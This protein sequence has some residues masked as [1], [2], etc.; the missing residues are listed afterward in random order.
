MGIIYAKPWHWGWCS[1]PGGGLVRAGRE[2][3]FPPAPGVI[4][5]GTE[6]LRA[7]R[8]KSGAELYNL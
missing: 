8:A 6:N 5:N 2:V 4:V 7:C 3:R 1:L